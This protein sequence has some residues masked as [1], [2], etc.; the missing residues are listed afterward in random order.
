MERPYKVEN[1]IISRAGV[2]SS[3]SHVSCHSDLEQEN[4]LLTGLQ[5]QQNVENTNVLT[6]KQVFFVVVLGEDIS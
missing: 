3:T 6:S 1:L 4:N 5:Q 2:N